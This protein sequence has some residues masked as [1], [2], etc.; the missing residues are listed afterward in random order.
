MLLGVY[1]YSRED[2][3]QRKT[4]GRTESKQLETVYIAA[5]KCWRTWSGTAFLLQIFPLG[6]ITHVWSRKD[7]D[8]IRRLIS[9]LL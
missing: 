5:R 4:V 2:M 3:R 8:L 7:P 6:N 1:E 9:W